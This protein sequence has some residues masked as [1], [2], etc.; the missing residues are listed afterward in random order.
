IEKCEWYR[1]KGSTPMRPYVFGE[2]LIGVSVSDGDIPEE[3]GMIAHNPNDLAD[4]WYI[5]KDYFD[6]YE[7]A[8]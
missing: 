1:K 2:N 6:E 8:R 7:V 5:S 3:G 4:K